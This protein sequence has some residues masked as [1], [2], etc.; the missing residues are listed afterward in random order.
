MH[1][2]ASHFLA[3]KVNKAIATIVRNEQLS[4]RQQSSVVCRGFLHRH[5]RF[6]NAIPTIPIGC[7]I[8]NGMKL[9]RDFG[10]F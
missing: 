1:H 7:R 9:E 6:L 3:R 10:D 8:I 5:M 2:N 4:L